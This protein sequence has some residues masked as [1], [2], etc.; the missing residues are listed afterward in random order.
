MSNRTLSAMLDGIPQSEIE[1]TYSTYRMSERRFQKT[2]MSRSNKPFQ[3]YS[4]S[5]IRASHIRSGVT[6]RVDSNIDTP[7]PADEWNITVHSMPAAQITQF[8]R[9]LEDEGFTQI[10][11][12]FID[13]NKQ[14]GVIANQS[15]DI[16]FDG[17]HLTFKYFSQF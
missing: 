1:V 2:K 16:G 15:L 9:C 4:H 13:T 11:N 10:K 14:Q 17:K 8:R 12:W 7:E 6:T 3:D 5:I